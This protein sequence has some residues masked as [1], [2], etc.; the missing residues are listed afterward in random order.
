MLYWW[1]IW[2]I[3]VSITAFCRCVFF[4]LAERSHSFLEPSFRTSNRRKTIESWNIHNSS[5][6]LWTP[7][8]T[9]EPASANFKTSS[10]LKP[11][12]LDLVRVDASLFEW[13]IMG[14]RKGIR[15]EEI[16]L[17]FI[18]MGAKGGSV[19]LL[20]RVEGG[21]SIVSGKTWFVYIA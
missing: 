10:R 21:E 17:G 6:S 2:K 7:L 20:D 18:L 15:V 16:Q 19:I 14:A 11:I 5:F 13:L 9:F 4:E 12:V 8:V 3:L 1:S